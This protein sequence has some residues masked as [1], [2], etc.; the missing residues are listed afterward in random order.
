MGL[1]VR[2]TGQPVAGHQFFGAAG[3]SGRDRLD[4]ERPG[5]RTGLIHHRQSGAYRDRSRQYEQCAGAESHP[6]GN[7]HGAKRHRDRCSRLI[8]YGQF[9]KFLSEQLSFHAN[10]KIFDERFEENGDGPFRFVS[11]REACEQPVVVFAV[12]MENFQGLLKKVAPLIRPGALVMDVCSLKVFPK[13]WMEETLAET[14]EILGTHPL[15]GPQSAKGGVEGMKI[16]LCPVRC[17]EERL[18]QVERFLID[19]GLVVLQ[20]SAQEHDRQMAL[21]QALTHFV[22]RCI[23]RMELPEIA[24]S[25]KTFENLLGIVRIIQEDSPVLFVNI[26]TLNPYAS[27]VR[28]LF[29]EKGLGLHE[30]LRLRHD[31]VHE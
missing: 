19:R 23:Q 17:S 20:C 5:R 8:G 26:Q 29:L 9:G 15:F 16:A 1:P 3:K 13:Q 4:H 11:L 14:V 6:G 12:P 24:L 30:E 28:S 21:S 22:G 10:L 7:W 27:H 2:R 18:M 25:T 31:G